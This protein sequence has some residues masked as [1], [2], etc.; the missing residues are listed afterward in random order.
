ML[1]VVWG[2]VLMRL[3]ELVPVL[4]RGARPMLGLLRPVLVRRR[5]RSALLGSMA[6]Q[7]MVL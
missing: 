4:V 2:S 7:S 3:Q 6:L 1:V 5:V